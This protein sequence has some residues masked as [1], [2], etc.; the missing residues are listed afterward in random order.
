MGDPSAPVVLFGAGNMGGAIAA[1]WLKADPPLRPTIIAPRPRGIVQD[2]ANTDRIDLNPEPI[3]AGVLM[4][5]VKPQV[6]PS[7]VDDLKAWIGPETLVISIM[8][9]VTLS[10]MAKALGTDRCI[11][12]MPNT[13][14]AIGKG[15]AL[16][17]PSTACTGADME[18]ANALLSPLG[19]VEGPLDEATLQA[20]TGLS[21]CGPA[22]VFLM[23][24]ALADAAEALGVPADMA[25][26]LAVHT[27]EGSASLLAASDQPSA[28]LRRAVTSPNGVTQAAL[29]VLMADGAMPSLFKD[30][31]KAALARDKALS[32]ST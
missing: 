25:A 6:F 14:G 21:G 23:A 24:E 12:V 17:S 15:V 27:V 19:H 22:Y 20:A 30:A 3:S 8:A 1:G 16:V 11:R 7:V 28:D 5:G 9:G 29:E 31:L 26:R 13:P 18:T 4:V 10:G 32:G 2:W